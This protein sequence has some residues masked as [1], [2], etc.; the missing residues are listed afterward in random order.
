MLTYV[1]I[2]FFSFFFFLQNATIATVFDD[3]ISLF[4]YLFIRPSPI[5][6]TIMRYQRN[7][8]TADKKLL[9]VQCNMSGGATMSVFMVSSVCLII[10]LSPR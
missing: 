7:F 4:I 1:R 9:Y 3:A 5:V 2:T 10:A 6:K 8:T